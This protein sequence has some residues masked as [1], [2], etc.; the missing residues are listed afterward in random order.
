MVWCRLSGVPV[1][2]D[3]EQWMIWSCVT[4]KVDL[5]YYTQGSTTPF[6][7]FEEH[8]SIPSLVEK[9]KVLQTIW[10]FLGPELGSCN[11]SAW[12]PVLKPPWEVAS[13]SWLGV[14]FGGNGESP[15]P[16]FGL[17]ESGD[18]GVRINV[19]VRYAHVTS[20]YIVVAGWQQS[21]DQLRSK[22]IH[23]KRGEASSE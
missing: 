13:Q 6:Y 11:P 12:Q 17:A 3:A 1:A 21:Q 19:A 18:A 22:K 4:C 10:A 9:P 8:I 7:Y 23:F 20:I 14:V 5:I 16:L 15:Y 2:A